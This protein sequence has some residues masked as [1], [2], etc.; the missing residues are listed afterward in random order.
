MADNITIA[1]P[2]AKAVFDFA[3]ESKTVEK[4]KLFLTALS[5]L[6]NSSKIV[7]FA[8]VNSKENTVSCILKILDGFIDNYRLNFVNILVESNRLSISK[9]ILE[10]FEWYSNK[11]S[12]FEKA[13]VSSATKLSDFDLNKLKVKLEAKHKCSITLV[14]NI[15]P[16]LIA[17]LIVKVGDEVIDSSIRS[18]LDK[19]SNALQS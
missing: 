19:L 9:E 16:T 7:S 4:W 1:R 14:N 11:E 10:V 8:E 6:V 15:D 18:R 12:N 2:Y 5:E 13:E 17:G 3:R